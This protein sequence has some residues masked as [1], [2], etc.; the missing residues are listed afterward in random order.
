MYQDRIKVVG[1]DMMCFPADPLTLEPIGASSYD[2]YAW[3]HPENEPAET[4]GI[5]EWQLRR[6]DIANKGHKSDSIARN[7]ERPNPALGK[8]QSKFDKKCS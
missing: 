4:I 3:S 6:K 7:K 5:N 8:M 2:P 1:L